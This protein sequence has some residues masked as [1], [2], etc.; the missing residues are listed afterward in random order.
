MS[1]SIPM[2]V[3]YTGV[4]GLPLRWWSQIAAILLVV[5]ELCW[6]LPWFYLVT[7]I[8]SVA[9]PWET[10][11]VLGGTMF[12]TYI[13]GAWLESL[14]LLR[15][16]ELALI[17]FMLIVSLLVSEN[18]LL[19]SPVLGG[20]NGLARL[21]PGAV[22]VLFF[23]LWMWWRGITLSR[24]AIRPIIAWRRFELGLLFF[25]AYIF[26]AARM[27]F[28]VPG[29]GV[30]MLFLSSGLLAVVFAR[31]SYVGLSKG[32][33]KNPFDLRWLASIGG[34]LGLTVVFAALMG[35]LLTGQYSRFL[36][37]LSEAIKYLIAGVLFILGIP[38][39][40]LSYFLGP[41]I[42]WL[43][44]FLATPTSNSTPEYPPAYPYPASLTG[45]ELI[46]LPLSFQMICFWSL[47]LVLILVLI[48]RIRKALGVRRSLEPWEP[49]SLL[50]RGEAPALLRKAFRDALSDL[51]SRFR[52]PPR[53]MVAARIRRIYAQLMDLSAELNRPRPSSYTPL[54]FLPELGEL[55]SQNIGDLE[56]LTSAYLKVRY[57]ELPESKEEMDAI[58]SAWQNVL[59][60]GHRLK[61]AG[62][63][64][65][66]T[67]EIKDVE[68][69]GV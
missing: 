28:Y 69:K 31:I 53:L 57:G 66:K 54:E 1:D 41:V 46:Q 47:I 48:F 38:G 23:V 43:Q 40:I 33:S 51:A 65:L 44:N 21:D 27:D 10:A 56:L 35:S 32:V 30:F 36:D 22:L 61:R 39:L 24:Q 50:K 16:V 9:P 12:I 17:G 59:E 62:V 19:D 67:V 49:E 18:L 15:N 64:K 20:V 55:F 5:V 11:L 37:F 29:P 13:L 68:R 3:N 52:S 6:L 60:A 7:Q 26:I 4:E 45:Q 63:G 42:P 58:E 14:R 34:I 8:T 25:M 2:Q